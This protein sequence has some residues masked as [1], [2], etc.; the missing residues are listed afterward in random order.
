MRKITAE[1]LVGRGNVGRPDI[2]GVSTAEMQR[3]MDEIPREVIVPAFNELSEQMDSALNDRYT[4]AETDKKINDKVVEVGAADMTKAVYDPENNGVNVTVQPYTCVKTGTVYALTGNGAAG[5]CKIPEAFNAGDTFTVNGQA[6]PAY[7]G[8]DA[9]DGDCIVAGRWVFF[10][11][12]GSQINFSGGGGL[13]TSKLAQ[14]TAVE[15]HVLRGKGFYAGGKSLRT[16][17]LPNLAFAKSA[18][19]D[20]ATGLDSNYPNV[21][22]DVTGRCLYTT[23]IDGVNR[24]C[25]RPH[26]G[27]FGGDSNV[28]GVD[29]YVGID[30]NVLGTA[31]AAQ[32]LEGA[33]FTSGESG[34]AG[35]GGSMINRGNWSAQI[36]PGGV[37]T[38]P[39]GYH[40]GGGSVSAVALK[41][42]TITCAPSTT[43]WT[44]TFTG[45]TL[46]GITD[47]GSHQQYGD[48]SSE[49]AYLRISGNTIT[50]A[51]SG[52]GLINR[53]ITLLYY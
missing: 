29:G 42:M 33:S 48:Y 3:I 34:G 41:T 15:N 40:A 31:N 10:T 25:L 39:P 35:A 49:I 18:G 38:V 45:G 30:A 37:V 13:S 53:Q 17:T 23:N 2:P 19:G 43:L 11:F 4:K 12:D 7:C 28:L 44:Y 47:I 22:V 16:G 14:A 32:V 8:A 52:N 24:L 21:G 20:A 36:S 1:E 51:W 26:F 9:V 50:L 46:V 27:V 5:R 6:A